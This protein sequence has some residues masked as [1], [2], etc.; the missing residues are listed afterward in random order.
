MCV[1]GMYATHY[2]STVEVQNTPSCVC[3]WLTV[4]HYLYIYHT[5]HCSLQASPRFA[6]IGCADLFAMSAVV[7]RTGHADGCGMVSA[8]KLV[9]I[10]SLHTYTLV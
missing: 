9:N 7:H 4:L 1:A 5:L 8:C 2:A 3:T 10:H 6:K